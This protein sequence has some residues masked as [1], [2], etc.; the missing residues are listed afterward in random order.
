MYL[1]KIRP[2][3]AGEKK[4]RVVA[5]DIDTGDFEVADKVLPAAQPLLDRRPGANIWMERIGFPTLRHFGGWRHSGK[6]K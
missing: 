5:I 3:L 1:R 2:K 4:G 6:S